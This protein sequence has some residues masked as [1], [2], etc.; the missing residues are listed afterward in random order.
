MLVSDDISLKVLLVR[1]QVSRK[2]IKSVVDIL[3]NDVLGLLDDGPDNIF[4]LKNIPKKKDK[5]DFVA[6]RKPC[7]N[8][9]DYDAKFKNIVFYKGQSDT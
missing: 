3:E 8:F 7:K 2:V 6:R 9:K 5:T 1:E 4:N